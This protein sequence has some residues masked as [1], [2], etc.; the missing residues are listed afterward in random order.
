MVFH[1]GTYYYFMEIGSGTEGTDIYLA[2]HA[3]NLTE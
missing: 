2:T 3:G 1:N